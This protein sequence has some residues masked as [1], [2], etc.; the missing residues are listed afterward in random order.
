[1]QL[2]LVIAA[3]I[4][5]TPVAL[6]QPE[7]FDLVIVN[8]RVI[9]GTGAPAR[10]AAIGVRAGKIAR[11]GAGVTAGQ[12]ATVI[13]AKGEVVAPGFIDVHTHA[14]DLADSPGAVNFVRMGVTTI[15]AGNCGAS[16]L[17]IGAALERITQ[18]GPAINF[19]TLI[20]HNTVRS[21]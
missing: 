11:I 20:G 8:G 1:M 15:V 3:L 2:R 21:R 12:G 9:D 6:A 16:A 5:L 7:S 14:D 17:D 13:D 10:A 19:A 18:A 4:A